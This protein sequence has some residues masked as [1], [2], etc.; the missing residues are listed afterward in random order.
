MRHSLAQRLPIAIGLICL[1]NLLVLM[2]LTRSLVLPLKS[3]IMNALTIAA[4]FGCLVLV[5]QHG[6]LADLLGTTGQG[7]LDTTQ[8]ILPVRPRVRVVD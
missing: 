3:L 7:A 4:T 6:Y 5:F 1:A 8:S 2:A